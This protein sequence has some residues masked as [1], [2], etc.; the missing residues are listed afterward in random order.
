[1]HIWPCFGC[2]LLC[3]FLI[4]KYFFLKKPSTD[5]L[6]NHLKSLF[7]I[8]FIIF[9]R[10]IQSD[11]PK[12]LVAAFR[13]CGHH[14]P[15]YCQMSLYAIRSQ[16]WLSGQ[17]CD[18]MVIVVTSSSFEN[19]VTIPLPN[20]NSPQFAKSAAYLLKANPTMLWQS[21]GRQHCIV[22]SACNQS[23]EPQTICITMS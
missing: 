5:F 18:N 9:H 7:Y 12:N 8:Y 20:S 6:K 11:L 23:W 16:P 10:K 19:F 2:L 21:L 22:G 1:M 17:K 14:S 13:Q 4:L 3:P 15:M